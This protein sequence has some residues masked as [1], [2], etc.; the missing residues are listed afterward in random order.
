M[1]WVIRGMLFGPLGNGCHLAGFTFRV[2]T[3]AALVFFRAAR[4]TG[5][6]CGVVTFVDCVFIA[7]HVGSA[8]WHSA[9]NL[10][11]FA[12]EHFLELLVGANRRV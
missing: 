10:A 4:C 8:A 7:A 5:G 12:G 6:G 11:N 1:G 2:F 3:V 9:V